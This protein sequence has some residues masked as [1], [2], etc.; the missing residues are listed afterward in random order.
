MAESIGGMA[1]VENEAVVSL[2]DM[3]YGLQGGLGFYRA[4]ITMQLHCPRRE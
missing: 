3:Q 1:E 4:G 2:R